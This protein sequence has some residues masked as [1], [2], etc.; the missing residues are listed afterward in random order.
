MKSTLGE[1]AKQSAPLSRD[2]KNSLII[3]Y[4]SLVKITAYRL[5]ARLPSD[6]LLDDLISCGNIGLLEALESFNP[7]LMIKFETFAK[8]RIR[9]AMLDE[10]RSRDWI[11]R[12][13]RQKMRELDSLQ[14]K[15]STD[16]SRM[17]ADEE[18][19]KALEMSLE[20][21]YDMILYVQ[22]GGMVSYDQIINNYGDDKNL[23]DFLEDRSSPHPDVEIQIK[24]L[25]RRIIDA[26]EKLSQEEQLAMA[27]YYY[28]GLTLKEIA[29]VIRVSESRVS[30]IH[31]KALSKLNWKLSKYRDDVEDLEQLR[32][33]E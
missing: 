2:E 5:A 16:L 14:K 22:P 4:A 21:Y 19:A 29:E 15:L 24:E 1:Y 26:L 31:A 13:V 9:G 25:K 28:E 8:F 20:D 6:H 12:S 32:T 3:K 23:L 10:M 30:Q 11:P 27:L 7:R 17:P 18:M 33:A